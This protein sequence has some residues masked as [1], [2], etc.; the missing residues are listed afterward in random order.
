MYIMYNGIINLKLLTR[1]NLR[2]VL[3]EGY[4]GKYFKLEA[5]KKIDY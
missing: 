4:V 5:K 3:L 1:S 2:D